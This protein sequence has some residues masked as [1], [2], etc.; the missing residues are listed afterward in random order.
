MQGATLGTTH[1]PHP[2][3]NPAREGLLFPISQIR[4]LRYREAELP[5]VSRGALF[6]GLFAGSSPGLSLPGISLRDLPGWN[7]PEATKCAL[8]TWP[9]T[10]EQACWGV[11][12]SCWGGGG[13]QRWARSVASAPGLAGQEGSV[14]GCVGGDTPCPLYGGFAPLR[15]GVLLQGR[16]APTSRVGGGLGE[17]GEG[18]S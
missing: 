12:C 14:R 15:G 11:T 16:D 10:R 6:A 1:S 9:S 8:S 7:Q 13:I 5:R 2:P 18:A 4:R 17:K 3:G